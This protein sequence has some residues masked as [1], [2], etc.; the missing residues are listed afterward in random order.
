MI[1]PPA[2]SEMWTDIAP[3]EE[4]LDAIEKRLLALETEADEG[5]LPHDP[6]LNDD[7]C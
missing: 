4:R 5:D 2:G 3:L 1:P 7:G 6:P